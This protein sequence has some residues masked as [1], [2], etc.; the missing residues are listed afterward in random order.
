VDGADVPVSAGRP[1]DVDHVVVGLGGLG[2]AAA[3]W[4][5]RLSD[6]AGRPARVVGLEQYALGHDRGASQD[7]SRIIRLSYHTPHYVALA[8]QAYRAWADVE[9]ELG[10]SLIVRTGGLDLWP[11]G[12][13]I[14]MEDYTSSLVAEGVPFEL[15]DAAEI[16]RRYPPFRLDGDVVGLFQADA[17]I[18]PA[19][20][21]NAAHQQL[22]TARGAELRAHTAVSGIHSDGAGELNVTA[23]GAT[24]RTGS[25]VVCA[26]AWTN[27]VLAPLGVRLPLTVTR[28]QVAYFPVRDPDGFAPERFPVWIWMDDPSF[29]GLPVFGEP[30][31]V[32]AAEDVGGQPTTAATRT[33]DSDE[34]ALHRLTGFLARTV[35][36][37]VDGRTPRVKTCLYTLTP[38]R[39]FVLG[40]VPGHPG[41]QVAL[42]AAHGYKFASWFGRTLAERAVHG[43]AGDDLAPFRIDRPV[44]LDPNPPVHHLV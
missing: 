33:F 7:H 39:D 12:A 10:R 8:R 16:V 19:A 11:R 36:G 22:A 30:G 31:A 5:A 41:V 3:Y 35:P 1:V 6:E 42:G 23:A 4:L 21:G 43:S 14:P 38:D 27:D 28:E 34:A 25:L 24:Y 37:M 40:D 29:Y 44:L 32:K 9:A 2:S 26:D 13:A 18:A 17:G 20:L 15:L